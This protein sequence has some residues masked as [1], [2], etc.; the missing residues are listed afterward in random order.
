MTLNHFLRLFAH[1]M[2]AE[3]AKN[4]PSRLTDDL[5]ANRA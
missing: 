2:V 1:C 3:T 5:P 4:A